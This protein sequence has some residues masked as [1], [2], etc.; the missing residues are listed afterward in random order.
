MTAA[1]VRLWRGLQWSERYG[2]HP[3]TV[4]L[5]AFLLMGAVAGGVDID[6]FDVVPDRSRF[7]RRFPRKL[8]GDLIDAGGGQPSGKTR[9]EGEDAQSSG[10][11]RIDGHVWSSSGWAESVWFDL[12]TGWWVVSSGCR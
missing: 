5:C 3:G 6:D 4:P 8:H 10:G 1:I 11:R 2:S 12:M 7:Q 9:I